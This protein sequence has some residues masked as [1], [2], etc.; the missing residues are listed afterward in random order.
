MEK[1]IFLRPLN[2]EDAPR[3]LE[4]MHDEDATHYLRINGSATT[5]EDV[6]RFIASA[7]DESVTVHRAISD[8][9]GAY[10]GTISLKDVDWQKKEA[11]Y[12]MGNPKA[13]SACIYHGQRCGP[14]CL[15]KYFPLCI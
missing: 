4:W 7:Q 14:D 13:H 3:M 10:L 2:D 11:E 6:K 12:A 5:I 1:H 8:E 15:G 9:Q